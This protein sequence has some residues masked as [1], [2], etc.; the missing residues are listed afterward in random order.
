MKDEIEAVCQREN[1]TRYSA[2][3]EREI[4]SNINNPLPDNISA[5]I[6]STDPHLNDGQIHLNRHTEIITQSYR[7][8][9]LR[10]KT[11]V[12]VQVCGF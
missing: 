12:N 10:Y 11:L 3:E 8:A 6:R 5:V 4:L 1:Q 2:A 9:C 7:E